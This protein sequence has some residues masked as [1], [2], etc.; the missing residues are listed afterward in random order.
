[1][2]RSVRN[3]F[4][5]VAINHSTA[6]S[7]CGVSWRANRFYRRKMSKYHRDVWNSGG[8]KGNRIDFQ[9]QVRN[10]ETLVGAIA[11]QIEDSCVEWPEGDEAE[12]KFPFVIVARIAIPSQGQDI[13]G[14]EQRS[15]CEDLI[16]SP[17]NGLAD[18]RPLGGINRLRQAVYA[19]SA[20]MRRVVGTE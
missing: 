8:G 15:F 20:E 13:E 4:V 5:A 17:W 14:P 18:H 7:G 6:F 9:V 11:D 10:G 3:G 12:G 16:F 1:M 2:T 19:A